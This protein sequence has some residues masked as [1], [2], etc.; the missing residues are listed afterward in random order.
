LFLGDQTMFD[1]RSESMARE[2]AQPTAVP[3]AADQG[4]TALTSLLENLEEVAQSETSP[5]Y[6]ADSAHQNRLV[7]VRLGVASGLFLAL[8]VKHAPTAAHSLRVALACSSWSLRLG[9]DS[10]QRDELEVAALL[11]DI[12]KIGVPDAL[13]SKPGRLSKEEMAIMNRH[14]AHSRE[15]LSACSASS[16]LLRI[17]WYAPAWF[18][19]R[20]PEFDCKGEDLPLGARIL[21]IVDAFD[22]MTTDHLYRRALSRERAMAELFEHA[23]TQFDP[24]LVREFHGFFQA[25][26]NRLA[27]SVTRRWLHDLMRQPKDDFWRLN[28]PADQDDVASVHRLFHEQLLDNMHDSVVFLDADLTIRRWNRAIEFLTGIPST[29]A[30]NQ[31]WDPAILQVR[32]ENFKLV[33]AGNC[34]VTQAIRSGTMASCRLYISDAKQEKV[35][36]DAH[37]TPVVDSEGQVHGATLLL[38]DASSRISLEERVQTLHER[39]TQ[40][41]LTRVANR[42]ELDRVHKEWVKLHLEKGSPYS[43]IICDLD[44]FKKINDTFGHQAGD[45]ALVTF[46]SILKK[47]CRATDLVARYGGEEF[48]VLCPDCDNATATVRAEAIREALG[49]RPHPTL[50]GKCVT[51]SFGVTELQP[52]DTPETMLRRADRALLQ[53]KDDGRNAVVQLGAG[54]SEGPLPRS[55]RRGWLAWLHHDPGQLLLSRKVI[56]AVPLNLAVEKLRGFISDN[57]AEIIDISESRVTLGIDGKSD[58]LHRRSTDHPTAF[59]IEL[60]LREIIWDQ[61]AVGE[62][63]SVRTVVH[64][65]IRPK[66]HRDRRRRDST[67]RARRL[68]LGLKSYL[69]AQDYDH[70]GK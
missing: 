30:E 59:L 11:H 64:V 69:M 36:I 61:P 68:L 16:E 41:G 53:A 57:K 6:S 46:A 50:D 40:D 58:L 28:H 33:T 10:S 7:Q 32:D 2:S 13:L 38:Q 62:S 49:A 51:A 27:E 34:P 42:A 56:T 4:I 39:V 14:R 48:V 23:G 37:I 22:A 29:R 66:R 44:H 20:R 26:H 63:V 5:R 67:E 25:N 9:L 52:G 1:Q 3:A 24:A 65:T 31:P 35:S 60:E 15:I 70:L 54:M 43:M 18:D 12:G 21:S 8:R 55:R 47:F 45:D 17:V 19:G